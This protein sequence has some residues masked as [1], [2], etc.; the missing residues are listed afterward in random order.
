MNSKLSGQH[1]QIILF[2][3]QEAREAFRSLF[4][5]KQHVPESNEFQEFS[6]EVQ[7]GAI[8]EYNESIPPYD[9]V[10]ASCEIDRK[11]HF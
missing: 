4:L 3:L 11:Y 10:G 8:R 7:A 2:H 1:S 5:V 6:S 9:E